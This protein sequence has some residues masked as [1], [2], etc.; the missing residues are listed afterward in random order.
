MLHE[1]GMTLVSERSMPCL[2][3]TH[4][5]KPT[6]HN[7][8]DT[9]TQAQGRQAHVEAAK[10]GNKAEMTARLANFRCVHKLFQSSET[11]PP[12]ASSSFPPSISPTRNVVLMLKDLPSAVQF[13][14]KEGLGLALKRRSE[15]TAEFDTGGPPLV[16]KAV[17][18][19]AMRSTG[20]SP[21]L[22]FDVMDMDSTVVRL[23][24][25]GASLD[26]PIKYP[27]YGKV[28]LRGGGWCDRVWGWGVRARVGMPFC[29][30]SNHK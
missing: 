27:A 14:G 8:I 11:S 20:Y 7:N 18:G 15:M 12:P 23:L 19:E 30:A 21:F 22:C 24:Q 28:S 2:L 29:D 26:G 3:W 5:S 6:P 10:V 25:L 9:Q 16:L 1:C 13:Y 17:E 4:D